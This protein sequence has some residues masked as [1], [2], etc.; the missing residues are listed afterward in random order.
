MHTR[1]YDEKERMSLRDRKAYYDQMVRWVVVHAYDNVPAIQEKMS[2]AGVQPAGVNRAVDLQKIPISRLSDVVNAQTRQPPFGGF[3][4]VPVAKLKRLFMVPGPEFVAMGSSSALFRV[5]AK[6]FYANGVRAGDLVINVWPY[7]PT[8]AGLAIDEGCALLG[9]TIIPAGPGNTD[10][11]I[12]L[13]QRVKPTVFTGS[14]SYLMTMIR[15]IEELGHEFRRSFGFRLAICGGETLAPSLRQAFEQK[16]GMAVADNYGVAGVGVVA[17]DCGEGAGKHVAEEV[18]V[19]VVDSAGRPVAAGEVGECVVTYFDPTYPMIR[20]GT[21]DLVSYDD[22]P[23]TCGRTSRRIVGIHGRSVE[24]V[25]VRALFL[26]PE[27]LETV[28]AKF[29]EVQAF[30]ALVSREGDQDCLKIS[31][32]TEAGL[33]ED[34]RSQIMQ[35][36]HDVCRIRVDDVC[37]VPQGTIPTGSRRIV[38]NRVWE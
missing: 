23:C 27:Q 1:F 13:M 6:A 29:P 26:H 16:Y 22:E 32:E 3:L 36:V 12:E 7:H 14:G 8:F 33:E 15:R 4:A 9:V 28:I 38:D 24:S 5:M 17:Y 20:F 30:Q 37:V 31:V 11:K 21:G 25:K 19:E 18:L 35:A 34:F 2:R 10:L